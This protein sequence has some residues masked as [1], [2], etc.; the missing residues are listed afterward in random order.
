[1]KRIQF[2]TGTM[3]AMKSATLM[4]RHFNYNKKGLKTL[5][6]KPYKD[7]RDGDK[8]ISRAFIN[9]PISALVIKEAE[10]LECLMNLHE[11]D[12]IM[13]DEVQF[14]DVDSIK[15]LESLCYYQGITVEVYGLLTDYLGNAFPASQRLMSC[16]NVQVINSLCKCGNEAY[17]NM[18]LLNGKPFFGEAPQIAVGDVNSNDVISYEPKCGR[19]YLDA[20][21]DWDLDKYD[22]MMEG[23]KNEEEK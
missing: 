2:F 23:F 22:K 5:V 3:D 6:L 7:G 12:V 1:M 4:M 15:V 18:R 8:V 13:V 11:Y 10:E 14:F 20:N 16:A 17:Y 19:C 9:D 21:I